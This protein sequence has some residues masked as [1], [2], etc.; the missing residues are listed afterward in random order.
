MECLQENSSLLES[1]QREAVG[2]RGGQTHRQTYMH[3][4]EREKERERER[5]R[6]N[7]EEE[8]V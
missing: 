8:R 7:E 1:V 3:T 5:E 4:R 6:E 2:A